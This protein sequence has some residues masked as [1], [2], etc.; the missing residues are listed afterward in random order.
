M[1]K[2]I[3]FVFLLVIGIASFLAGILFN[4]PSGGKDQIAK[5]VVQ[6][7]EVSARESQDESIET[8][9][10]SVRITPERQQLIGVKTYV[11]GKKSN[12]HT[13]R[14]LG[15]V[16]A[17]E[18]R[19]YFINATVD[20]WITE[21]LPKTTGSMVK[22]DETLARFYS[23]EFLSAEQ[24]LL[25]AL[26]SRDRIQTTGKETAPQRDQLTQFNINLQQFRDALKNLGMGDIQIEEMIKTRKYMGY[27]NVTSPSDGFLLA[28]N[29]SK[30]LRFD[31]GR[32]L[33]RIADLSR[34]WVL[35][36]V[37]GSEARYFKPGVNAK[38]ILPYQE[39]KYTAQVTNILPVFEPA[40]RTLKVR[41]EAENPG[42]FLRPE[43]FVDIE[44]P[45]QLPPAVA[46]PTDAVLDSGFKKT[47]FVE[48]GNGFF[49]S[50][51][52]E[53][54]W[55]AGNK[56]EIVRGLEPGERIVISGSFLIDS[57]SKLELAAAGMQRMFSKDPVCGLEVS[58]R[59]AEREGRKSVYGGKSYYFSSDEC[60]QKFDERPGHFIEI[61]NEEKS[62]VQK[63]PSTKALKDQRHDHS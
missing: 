30:G 17:D 19:V 49:E 28:R 61:S 24:A 41:L 5:Q 59:K 20:G 29:V 45:V 31:K 52:V 35:A 1:K 56:V 58:P 18:N 33:Y 21:V 42:Y 3:Y 13:L 38:V 43:M 63:T 7:K 12:S 37:Y 2:P 44:L 57:E 26:G 9:P 40:T 6:K 25:F 39:K 46:I 62:P 15:R 34:V 53:T 51:E 4:H 32:E 60:K 55:R 11:V 48:K 23:P 54:G 14:V 16:A 27:V 36:D 50:R 10:G 22:K 8:P 47:V